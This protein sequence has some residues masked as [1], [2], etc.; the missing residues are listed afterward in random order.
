[1]PEICYVCKYAPL[2]L[3]CGFGCSGRRL[4]PAPA[5]FDCADACTHPNLCG[6][7]KAVLEEVCGG[8]VEALVMTDCCDTMRRICE[9]AEAEGKTGFLALLPLPHRSGDAEVRLFAASLRALAARLETACG[10]PFEEAAAL[11]AW[12]CAAQEAAQREEEDRRA[13]HVTLRGAHG[14]SLLTAAVRAHLTLP[15]VDATCT[16]NRRLPPPAPGEGDFFDRYAAALLRQKNPCMRM[17]GRETQGVEANCAG[18]ICHT[19]KFCDYYG[20]EYSELKGA[21]HQPLLKIETDC[22]PASSGQLATRL[23]AFAETLGAQREQPAPTR[24][25]HL[26]AGVDSGSTSTD[27]VIMD[28]GRKILGAAILPTGAGA[29]AGAQHALEQA[30]AAAG[31][32]AAELDAVV[33]TGYGRET[34]G[35]AGE[36]VTEITCHARGAFFLHPQAR[37]VID[38]GGQDSKVIRM[39]EHGAVIN[40]IMND[41]CAAGTGRF[42]DMMARTLELSLDEMSRR[43]LEWKNEV[44]ISSMCTVFAESEVVSLVARNTPAEDIIH[45]LNLAVAGKTAALAKRLGGVPEYIMTGGVA[46]N[47]GVVRALEEKLGAPVFVPEQAQLCGAIGAALIALGD[48][49]AAQGA[50]PAPVH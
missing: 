3:F 25:A 47:E 39:D 7:G 15:V 33:T 36:S 8:G 37:T 10:R 40:F 44:K 19:V 16:G 4:D 21:V 11:S 41:K 49:P 18:V 23:D 45:G 50:Q 34:V 26:V 27:A 32:T 38:I 22:T 9:A 29:A 48:T 20:F 14:G 1:M 46:Q 35:L 17:N 2:E 30:L 24:R 43:G 31:V 13:P 28:A 12:S 5:A 6:F 42:L